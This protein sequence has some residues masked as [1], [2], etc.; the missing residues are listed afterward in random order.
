[1]SWRREDG[2]GSRG[3]VVAWLDVTSLFTSS[4]ERGLKQVRL[5]G[6]GEGGGRKEAGAKE[7]VMSFTNVLQNTLQIQKQ[8]VFLKSPDN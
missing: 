8:D 1:M 5:G 2:I 3:Q 4:E 7:E 6:V